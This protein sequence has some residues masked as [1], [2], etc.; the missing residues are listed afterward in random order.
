[1]AFVDRE[2]VVVLTLTIANDRIR[3]IH[4]IAD[5]QSCLS[6][7]LNWRCGPDRSLNYPDC[8]KI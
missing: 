3:K 2:L 1:M 7:M 6:S 4:A 8:K 5:P